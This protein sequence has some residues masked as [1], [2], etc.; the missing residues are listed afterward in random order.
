M[1]KRENVQQVYR[2]P[3]WPAYKFA[4]GV[5]LNEVLGSKPGGIF[6][7]VDVHVQCSQLLKNLECA[8]LSMVLCITNN[9]RNHA[10]ILGYSPVFKLL[11]VAILP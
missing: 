7:I 10:I 2:R 5:A 9:S 4:P 8:V 3:R 11:S 6:V 1:K